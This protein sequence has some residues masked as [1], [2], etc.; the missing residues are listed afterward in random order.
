MRDDVSLVL[1][2]STGAA[3]RVWAVVL[4]IDQRERERG[5]DK[6]VVTILRDKNG[7]AVC[8]HDSRGEHLETVQNHTNCEISIIYPSGVIK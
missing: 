8:L 7:G 1:G 4:L 6:L 5:E 3:E 2:G